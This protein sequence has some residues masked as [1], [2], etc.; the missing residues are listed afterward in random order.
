MSF[1]TSDMPEA[2]CGLIRRCDDAAH[3]RPVKTTH[4]SVS[5][6]G[7]PSIQSHMQSPQGPTMHGARTPPIQK[8]GG[9]VSE[10]LTVSTA[11]TSTIRKV[12][13]NL[14]AVSVAVYRQA[15]PGWNLKLAKAHTRLLSS[16]GL[17]PPI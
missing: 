13:S 4:E 14:L 6:R 9:V 16:C 3:G 2:G 10:Q 5:G 1:H 8:G 17:H 15:A 12:G 7:R 11:A